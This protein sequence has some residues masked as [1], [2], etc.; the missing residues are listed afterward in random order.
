MSTYVWKS[1]MEEIF[2]SYLPKVYELHLD[3]FLIAIKMSLYVN[4]SLVC[5]TLHLVFKTKNVDIAF[6]KQS[7]SD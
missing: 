7:M 4:I 6:N 1:E 5:Q 3:H 2:T